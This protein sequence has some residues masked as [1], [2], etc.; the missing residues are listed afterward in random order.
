LL[1]VLTCRDKPN[2]LDLRMAT[3]EDHIAYVRQN[4]E[5][6]IVKLGG[7]FLDAEGQMCGSMLIVET[8]DAAGAQAFSAGDPY[9]KAGLFESVEIRGYRVVTGGLAT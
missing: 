6:G 3:R 4:F 2:S 8:Y 1:F 5:A 7:P 9:T